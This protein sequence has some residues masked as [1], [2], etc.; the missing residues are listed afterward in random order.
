MWKQW[1]CCTLLSLMILSASAWPEWLNAQT[2]AVRSTQNSHNQL[3]AI[4]FMLNLLSQTSGCHTITLCFLCYSIQ[5]Q[6]ECNNNHIIQC[7]QYK[8][9][10]NTAK[11]YFASTTYNVRSYL[12]LAS[13]CMDACLQSNP[14]WV[15]CEETIYPKIQR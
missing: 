10:Q 7:I 14:G 3:S 13:S 6:N 9:L 12:Q 8:Y 11:K 5:T 2:Q 1:Q 4:G 15:S